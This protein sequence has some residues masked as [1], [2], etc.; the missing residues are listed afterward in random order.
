MGHPSERKQILLFLGGGNMVL[1][2]RQD[3][4]KNNMASRELMKKPK[5]ILFLRGAGRRH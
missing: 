3:Q 5:A 1:V 4:R 2:F